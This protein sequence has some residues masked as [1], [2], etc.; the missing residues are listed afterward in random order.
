MTIKTAAKTLQ[1]IAA[2]ESGGPDNIDYALRT[3]KASFHCGPLAAATATATYVL[4]EI[5]SGKTLS[6]KK[7]R[8]NPNITSTTHA[9][10][11]VTFTLGT[12]DGAA[13]SVTA[14]GHWS[15]DTGAEETLTEGT[16]VEF[17]GL[18]AD[19]SVTGGKYLVMTAANAGA[20]V[21]SDV[22]VLV[23]YELVGT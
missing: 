5:D 18:S 23:T 10:N 11:H 3:R 4:M 17:S 8:L 14:L 22:T 21:A 6:L 7:V 9:D 16:V 20:G 12:A 13:G 19:T 15:T 2:V 1:G